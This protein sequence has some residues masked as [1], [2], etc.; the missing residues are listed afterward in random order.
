[1]LSGALLSEARV[2]SFRHWLVLFHTLCWLLEPR[3]LCSY[4]RLADS[5]GKPRK[6]KEGSCVGEGLERMRRAFLRRAGIGGPLAKTLS[7][8][9]TTASSKPCGKLCSLLLTLVP[10]VLG[11]EP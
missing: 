7:C 11:Q 6:P 4:L 3:A 1:M 8:W 9:R 5:L 2:V 10:P